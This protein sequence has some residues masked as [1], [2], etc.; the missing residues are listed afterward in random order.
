MYYRFYTADVFTTKQ[1]GGNQLAIFPHAEGLD[2]HSMHMVAR[3]FNISE[4]V[5]VFPPE[6]PDNTRHLRIFTPS[7]ELPFA[8]HPSIG[9]AFTLAAIQEIPLYGESM[10]VKFEEE[11]GIVTVN[12]FTKDGK[13]TFA[14]LV[15]AVLPKF[16][17][18][19][20]DTKILASVL[21]IE[22]NDILKNDFSPQAVSCGVP[23][24]F[25]PLKDRSAL[26]RAHLNRE[27]W[28]EHL[29]HYWAP[30]LYLFTLDAGDPECS[31]RARMFAPAMGISEDPATGAGATALGGYLGSRNP[32][33]D[34]MLKWI[35]EQGI[36]MG[37]PSKLEVETDKKNGQIT[38][39]RV[40]G[41]C[42]MVSEG[43]I[44][45]SLG[46]ETGNS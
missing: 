8:G 34:G 36:E 12:I 27:K 29:S 13:P 26:S 11:V 16:G 41:S 3:E 43:L 10:E 38:A 45:I 5:F 22:S 4:T 39:I 19:P 28:R 17:P 31:I 30:H 24:L 20:P 14:Q 15:A 7:I 9:T 44:N 46:H 6:D 21:S 42:V 37:R 18:P 2:T 33:T 23:F 25:I 1:F 32:Q 40:G 35:I